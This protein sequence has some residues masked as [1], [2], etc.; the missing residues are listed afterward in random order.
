MLNVSFGTAAMRI[1]PGQKL[2]PAKA[3]M[4]TR[5]GAVSQSQSLASEDYVHLGEFGQY[6][7]AAL[8]GGA[9]KL[10][11]VRLSTHSYNPSPIDIAR[12]LIDKA[13]DR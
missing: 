8:R 10:S 1:E 9:Q 13:F 3:S 4:S 5:E 11:G 7:E 6:L 12:A 2:P